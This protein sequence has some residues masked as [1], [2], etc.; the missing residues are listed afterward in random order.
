LIESLKLKVESENEELF[1]S[2]VKEIKYWDFPKVSLYAVEEILNF[3]DF[4]LE[5]YFKIITLKYSK[6]SENQIDI[7]VEDYSK[8]IIWSSTNEKIIKEIQVIEDKIKIILNFFKLILPN[9]LH[10][11]I[12]A[13]F[14]N[15]SLIFKETMDLEIKTK[16]ID[17]MMLFNG[18]KRNT[19]D[20]NLDFVDFFTFGIY[21]R[22]ILTENIIEKSRKIDLI[23]EKNREGQQG[24]ILQLIFHY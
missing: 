4:L 24:K 11:D 5:N 19:I 20:S 14:D 16:I 17:I 12:F 23:R 7:L 18:V 8:N 22:P 9:S 21:L 1:L 3:A 2:A 6:E 13:S 10:K 15:L